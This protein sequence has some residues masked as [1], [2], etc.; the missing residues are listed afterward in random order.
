MFTVGHNSPVCT[1]GMDG[2]CAEWTIPRL[3]DAWKWTES[4]TGKRGMVRDIRFNTGAAQSRELDAV[5][6]EP[7]LRVTHSSADR[8]L[9]IQNVLEAVRSRR[10]IF[11]TNERSV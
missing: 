1:A 5:V 10:N 7:P 9:L 4:P 2:G 11:S 3:T 6:S 8:E